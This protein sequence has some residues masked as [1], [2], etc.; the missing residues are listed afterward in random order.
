MPQYIP[1]VKKLNNTYKMKISTLTF[2]L[3][4]AAVGLVS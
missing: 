3:P 2:N 1:A 4:I